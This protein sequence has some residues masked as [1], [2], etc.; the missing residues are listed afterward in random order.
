MIATRLMSL[1]S[2]LLSL[3]ST[4]LV[5]DLHAKELSAHAKNHSL[6][7]EIGPFHANQ[8]AYRI[9][10]QPVHNNLVMGKALIRSPRGLT[11]FC[12]LA[13]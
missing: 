7:P 4:I 12:I 9:R 3:Q 6:V 13:R 5:V 8:I 1:Q 11:P 2:D 10:E